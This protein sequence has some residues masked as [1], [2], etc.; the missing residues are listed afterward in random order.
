MVVGRLSGN[1][2]CPQIDQSNATAEF[3][4]DGEEVSTGA[5]GRP[6]LELTSLE[7][8]VHGIFAITMTLLVLNVQLPDH[9][10]SG[11][12]WSVVWGLRARLAAYVVGFV[13]LIAAWLEFRRG[14]HRHQTVEMGVQICWLLMLCTV[15]LTPFLV[16][17]LASSVGNSHDLATAIR[18]AVAVMVVGNVCGVVGVYIHHRPAGTLAVHGL[19]IMLLIDLGPALAAL[20]LSFWLPWLALTVLASGWLLQLAAGA[21]RRLW[22]RE[23]AASP[24]LS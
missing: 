3:I 18:I 21:L 13:Y 8:L 15:A 9:Y 14:F 17:M 23:A 22:V 19:A 16:S 7:M 4:C 12:L 6:P 10:A 1:G 24:A 2:C 11:H 5:E 20:A